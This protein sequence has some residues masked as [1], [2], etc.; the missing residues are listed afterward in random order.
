MEPGGPDAPLT[1][2]DVSSTTKVFVRA[3]PETDACG[4]LS[5]PFATSR[6]EDGVL[7]AGQRPDEWILLGRATAVGAVIDGLDRSGHVSVIDATHSRALFRLTG[8]D[9]ASVLE[10]LCSL[11]WNDHMTPDGAAVSGSVARV[12]CDIVR[13]DREGR[14]SYLISCDRS[15]GQY[16]FEVILDA[17][18]EFG[19][20]PAIIQII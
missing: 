5:T 7:I 16:L 18:Q 9:A 15:Y 13:N 17:G 14:R 6:T 4:R 1:L 2:Q 8:A 12:T 19:I 11:D 3:G 20:S 10:K